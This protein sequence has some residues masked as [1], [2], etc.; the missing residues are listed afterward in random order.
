MIDIFL[1]NMLPYGF[2]ILR[3]FNFMFYIV[4]VYDQD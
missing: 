2:Y 4:N 3:Y 1:Q